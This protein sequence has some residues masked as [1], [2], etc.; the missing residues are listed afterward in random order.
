MTLNRSLESNMK[1]IILS[2]LLF[3]YFIGAF[4]VQ[5]YLSVVP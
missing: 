2:I 5:Y 3:Q 1:L 4:S